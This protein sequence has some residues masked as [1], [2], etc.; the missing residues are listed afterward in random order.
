MSSHGPNLL[1]S[2]WMRGRHWAVMFRCSRC[3]RI[4][5]VEYRRAGN[6]GNLQCQPIPADWVSQ[7]DML[8]CPDCAT[9]FGEW[10]GAGR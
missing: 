8:L 2:G 3:R 5:T 7:G 1:H 10:M 6:E 4:E 9:S